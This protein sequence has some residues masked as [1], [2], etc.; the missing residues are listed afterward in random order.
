MHRNIRALF[1]KQVD[2]FTVTMV[3][4]LLLLGGLYG[5]LIHVERHITQHQIY[6]NKILRLQFLDFKLDNFIDNRWKHLNYD[7]VNADIRQFEVI[8]DEVLADKEEMVYH[9]SLFSSLQKV[10]NKFDE[11]KEYIEKVKSNNARIVNAVYFLFDQRKTLIESGTPSISLLDG[12]GESFLVMMKKFSN[13]PMNPKETKYILKKLKMLEQTHQTKEMKYFSLSFS[14]FIDDINELDHII[15]KLEEIE[16]YQELKKTEDVLYADYQKST[17]QQKIVATFFFFSSAL[18]IIVLLVFYLRTKRMNLEL[19]AYKYAIENGENMIMITDT[20]F[21]ITYVNDAFERITGYTKAEVVGKNPS[22]L[23]SGM[24]DKSIYQDLY[25]DLNQGKKWEGEFVNRHKNGQLIYEKVVISPLVYEHEVTGF[26]AIKL[27][28][29][30]IIKHQ[31]W[32]KQAAA[33]FENT[34]EGILILNSDKKI[35]T[36]NQVFLRMTHY[37][38]EDLKEK[39][40]KIFASGEY[41]TAFYERLWR[42]VDRHGKWSGKVNILQEN[43][44]SLPM[45]LSLSTVYDKN[46]K[47]INYI[48]IYADLSEVIRTQEKADFLAYHDSLTLLPNRPHFE[49]Y[50]RQLF[51]DGHDSSKKIA[52]LFLDLDRFKVI[53]DTLGHN[54]GDELLKVVAERIAASIGKG[55]FLARLGG[56]EFVV[57]IEEAESIEEVT[58][59]AQK[60]LKKVSE[61]IM[62][63]KHQLSISASIGIAL[64]PDHSSEYETLIKYADSAMYSAKEQGKN[65]FAYYTE[66]MS[67]DVRTRLGMEQHLKQAMQKREFSVM[68]QPQYD[69]HSKHIVGVEVLIRWDNKELGKVS[70]EEFIPIAEDTGLIVDMGYYIFEEACKT[71]MEWKA[72]GCAKINKLA[73]NISSVQLRQSDF[74]EKV[75]EIMQKTGMEGRHLE[76]E[77]TERILFEFSE[78]NVSLL[79]HFREMGFAVSI[80][81]FGTGYSSLSYLKDLPIDA[82]KIDKAFIRD[83]AENTHDQKVSKAIIALSKSLGYQVIA[84]GVETREQEKFLRVHG[85][86]IGQGYLYSKPLDKESFVEIIKEKE[87]Y[88]EEKKNG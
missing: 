69:L 19:L 41:D 21:K 73:F 14:N 81:D 51:S 62:A 48:A 74:V 12:M 78:H 3:F 32:L 54:V 47:V 5:Y 52:L 49:K 82:I 25:Q 8:L 18:F 40:L 24:M 65:T 17:V 75:E 27:D 13:A 28:I 31:N 39:R 70:P 80:D 26:I 15:Q 1:R 63:T 86:D 16:L 88:L 53:N 36:I 83:L 37:E 45:W 43:G 35:K 50:I 61:P 72:Q 59:C 42:S 57:I 9:E 20:D 38:K 64:Y 6:E 2:R 67:L 60:I 30:E 76:I 79:Q 55:H 7:E 29:S 22:I 71:F 66:Q 84:E 87:K 85:C 58:I 68:Y 10:K 46:E 4:F 23:K 44:N 77:L 34:Q 33:V 11:K 56:D